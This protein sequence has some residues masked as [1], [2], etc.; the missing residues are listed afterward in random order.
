[1]E[2][3]ETPTALKPVI[4]KNIGQRFVTAV[5][6]ALVCLTPLYFGGYAWAAIVTVL[7]LR[8][9]WEWVRMS[10]EGAPL[11]SYIIVFIGLLAT[12]FFAITDGF[13][14]AFVAAFVTAM[15]YG[16]ERARRG[17]IAWAFC[18]FLYV[19]IP[20]VLI[21]WL[22]GTGTGT[23]WTVRGF[24][25]LIYII[26]VVAAADVGAYLGGSLFKGPKMAPK[27]SPNK[28]W[29]GFLTGLVLGTIFGIGTSHLMGLPV[30][31]AL[32]TAP[33][34]IVASV[35]GDFLES[36][37]KRR[38]DVKDAGTLLP[39]HGGLLDRVDSL[40]MAVCLAALVLHLHPQIW[41]GLT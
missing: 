25:Q 36:G 6:F 11:M 37:L 41:P 2:R 33:P 24:Q 8:L 21:L 35:V 10:D 19:A 27:L 32:M 26:F 14:M 28:T 22:R 5:I 4:W 16:I 39:G 30:S 40:M 20:I 13:Q 17:G 29:S 3:S 7:G 23:G 34:L 31:F 9:M 1:M 18:G 15:A 12:L 38:L